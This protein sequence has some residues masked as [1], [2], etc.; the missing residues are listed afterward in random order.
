MIII[1]ATDTTIGML[2]RLW[3][4]C[5]ILDTPV[6]VVIPS[7][8]QRHLTQWDSETWRSNTFKQLAQQGLTFRYVSS[9]NPPNE[10]IQ[11]HFAIEKTQR[12]IISSN[13]TEQVVHS[14]QTISIT[15]VSTAGTYP[16]GRLSLLVDLRY[17]N[18]FDEDEPDRS[19]CSFCPHASNNRTELSTPFALPYQGSPETRSSET[20][21]LVKKAIQV[22]FPEE[23]LDVI[24]SVI[25]DG[26]IRGYAMYVGC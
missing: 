24:G 6:T 13:G 19:T 20:A 17:D 26:N 10:A 1:D 4:V 23:S 18:T 11:R 8:V 21:G 3:D 7:N 12:I 15:H 9:C 16:L 2:I 25:A 22:F 14:Q 5:A